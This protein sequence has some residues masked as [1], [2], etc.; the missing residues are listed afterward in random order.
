MAARKTTKAL[1]PEWR[2]KIQTT[3]LINRLENFV[4]GEIKMEPHQVT[5]ALGLL[6]KTL[7]DL[8]STQVS[9]D[10]EKPIKYVFE[11]NIPKSE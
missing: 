4:K 10:P 7:P 3:M 8:A 1:P 6:K 11:W 2:E 5:A 9:G